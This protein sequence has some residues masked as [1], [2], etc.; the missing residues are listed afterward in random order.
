MDQQITL[1]SVKAQ[2]GRFGV[3][4]DESAYEFCQRKRGRDRALWRGS[5]PMMPFRHASRTKSGPDTMVIGAHTAGNN[6]D[7]LRLSSSDINYLRR[8]IRV[9]TKC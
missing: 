1:R 7:F 4:R 9:G 5:A 3:L 8:T 6:K 2:S